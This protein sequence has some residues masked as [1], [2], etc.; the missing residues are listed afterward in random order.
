MVGRSDTPVP[1]PWRQE[2]QLAF[3]RSVLAQH[4]D[5][6]WTFVLLHQPLWEAPEINADW[7]A[8]E[9]MLGSRPYTV[10]AGHFHQYS[11]ARRNDRNFITLATTGGMS[12]LRGSALGEFDQVAWVTMRDDGPVI[13]NV[14]IDGIHDEGISTPA[15]RETL[16]ALI[17]GVSVESPLQ[18]GELFSGMAQK[19]SI[20]NPTAKPITASPSV[21]RSG[22]F[23]LS[24][25]VPVTVPPG[26]TVEMF[27]RL[28]TDAPVPYREIVPAGV[29][30]TLTAEVDGR[31]L[32]VPARKAVAPLTLHTIGRAE[33]LVTDGELSDWGALRF[34]VA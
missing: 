11:L 7:L 22:T 25:L 16:D 1:G 4:A 18:R 17:A 13:A 2:D 32:Q 12:A 14:E 3:A 23:A 26:E 33:G 5:A 34:Q 6:R 21:S 15:L 20:Y 28:S 19:V 31:L 10:F 30:W 24:G 29:E 27:M 8:V 9:E